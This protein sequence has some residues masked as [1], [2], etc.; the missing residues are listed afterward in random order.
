[1][2]STNM[3]FK[4]DSNLPARFNKFATWSYTKRSLMDSHNI[5][6]HYRKYVVLCSLCV[7]VY[8]VLASLF[9]NSR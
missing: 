6:S 2:Y 9:V 3:S 4:K 7:G 5:G 8:T 1:M